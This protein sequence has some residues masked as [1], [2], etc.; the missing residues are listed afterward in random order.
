M[1]MNDSNSNTT[2]DANNTLENPSS[3]NLETAAMKPEVKPE[4]KPE[5]RGEKNVPRAENWERSVLEKI[6][7]EGLKEQ[8]RKRRWGIFF[9]LATLVYVGVVIY[10]LSSFMTPANYEPHGP[11]TAVVK[12]EGVIDSEG[13]NSAD[14]IVTALQD[15]FEAP[16][17]KGVILRINSPGGSPVQ[18]G[19][20]NQ[21]IH[22][23]RA[24]HPTKPL[25]VVVDDICASGGSYIA[26]AANNIYV[27]KASL[28]GSI[29]VVFSS[30]GVQ[31][32]L[33]KL[34]VERRTLTAGDNKAFLDPFEPLNEAHKAHMQNLLTEVHQQ[35]IQVVREGRGKRLQ[36]NPDI[37][38]GLIW[39]GARA[40]EL[41]LADGFG[42]V[43]SVARD[44]LKAEELVDYTVEEDLAERLSKRIGI[45]AGAA[46]QQV[47]AK[48]G[49]QSGLKT[50]LK[51]QT[52]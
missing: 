45:S 21:E 11:H 3:V 26:A 39:N 10:G 43:Q 7:L 36:E 51:S 32:A 22:R 5:I 20:I 18:S 42:T 24:L 1:T 30:F 41:G 8:R 15:A 2:S 25:H 46:V 52:P 50:E 33:A 17:A 23:L 29:G 13:P 48:A 9:K 6:A 27:D 40:V 16:N 14:Y 49:L 44:V 35:F 19:V 12:I 37:F 38:S 28:V 4:V 31:E 47:L 34:G